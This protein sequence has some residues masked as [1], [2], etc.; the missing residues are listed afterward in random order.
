[1]WGLRFLYFSL[2]VPLYRSKTEAPPRS[3]PV[4]FVEVSA[5]KKPGNKASARLNSMRIPQALGG[6]GRW[7]DS[8]SSHK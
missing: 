7:S 6:S 8:I 5:I 1:M 2:L 4:R 3:L